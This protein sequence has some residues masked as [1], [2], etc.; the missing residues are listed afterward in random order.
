[1]SNTSSNKVCD[2]VRSGKPVYVAIP[3]R[4][5]SSACHS[6]YWADTGHR[7]HNDSQK[8]SLSLPDSNDL[9][10]VTTN[11][12]SSNTARAAANSS[13][14][15]SIV[16]FLAGAIVGV[17]FSVGGFECLQRL[18][19]RFL[20]FV[21]PEGTFVTRLSIFAFALAWSIVTSVTAYAVF[22]AL[23][24]RLQWISKHD[25]THLTT[26]TVSQQYEEEECDEAHDQTRSS[27][28][29]SSSPMDLHRTEYGFAIGVF[30]GFSAACAVSDISYGLSWICISGTV[31]TA[32]AWALLMAWCGRLG[33]PTYPSQPSEHNAQQRHLRK[34]TILPTVFV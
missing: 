33:L 1:M 21:L 9:C 30:L 6:P 28:S 16:A 24:H 23:F 19:D 20:F 8:L 13:A 31:I 15:V 5:A 29:S 26:V 4:I 34:G 7:K 10:P 22:S 32:L 18:Q 3:L 2:D 27:T 25:S 14:A 17:L 12:V 11:S